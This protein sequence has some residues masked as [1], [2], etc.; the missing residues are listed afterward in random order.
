MSFG[1]A[2]GKLGFKL[3]DVL[4]GLQS[5][6]TDT[7][8]S[9]ASTRNK[10]HTL[11]YMWDS[12]SLS[13]V[14]PQQS[15]TDA[16]L[17]ASPLPVSGPLTD[18]QLRASN[19]AVA[20]GDSANLDAFSRLRV[21]N[22][23]SMFSTQMQYNAG[24][25][26]M[27]SGATG[28]GAAGV[29]SA[30]TRMVALSCTAGTGTSFIQ[31]FRYISYQP[32]KSHE[33]AVTGVL[34]AAVAGAVVDVGYFDL[35]NGIFLRQNGT[36]GLQFVRRTS[37]SGSVVDN[38]VSQSSWNLDKLDGTGTSGI[39]LDVTTSFILFMDLQFLAMG[40]VR[41][42]FD[43]GGCLIYCHEFLNANVIAVPYMQT[44]TLPIQML[45]TAT[46]TGSTKTAYFKCAAVNSEGGFEQAGSFHFSTPEGTVTAASGARTHILS[47]RPRTTF[48]SIT[49]R[50]DFILD[51]VD[52]LVTGSNPVFWELCIGATFT[53]AP[54]YANVNATYS[55]FDYGTGGT[56]DN[57]T[58]GLVIA[59]GYISS[60]AT[61]KGSTSRDAT[62][63]YPITLDR[64][65]AVRALGTLSLLVSGIGGTSATRA[66]INYSEVR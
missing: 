22:P 52:L 43:I 60:S 56:F 64:A 46:A 30:D 49:N 31:S 14:V 26:Q 3:G 7:P 13:Y 61:A 66:A 20:L 15:V 24:G 9:I 58:S 42:G 6:T 65:G 18:T 45:I 11:G 62:L 23:T 47:V 40:R 19:V 27:E 12:D 35:A 33:I 44:G 29:H 38:A 10:L 16:E 39:T 17:R 28:T 41:I 48:N 2:P 50:E 59:S 34:G 53:V 8:E 63:R 51:T 25:L 37:T 4:I 21:S 5:G 1:L 54:T 36:S 55:A 32:L 57:L